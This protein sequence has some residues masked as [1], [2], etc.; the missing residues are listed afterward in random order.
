MTSDR[1]AQRL[2]RATARRLLSAHHARYRPAT[3]VRVIDSRSMAPLVQGNVE[4]LVSWG[5]VDGRLRPGA[6]VLTSTGGDLLVVHRAIDTNRCSSSAPK[7]LQMADNVDFGNP[8]A[9]SWVDERYVL[10]VVRALRA[11]DGRLVY[12]D[13][14]SVCRLVDRI[15][16]MGGR[17]LWRSSRRGSSVSTSALRLA[18]LAIMR[19]ACA[20]W[21]PLLVRSTVCD[22]PGSDAKEEETG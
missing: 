19:A 21:R 1:S 7:V 20:V 14:V 3:V 2:S 12:S 9:V 5:A 18:R 16:A 10:G 13:G 6:L 15:M 17:L 4:A 22:W 8:Y 11:P